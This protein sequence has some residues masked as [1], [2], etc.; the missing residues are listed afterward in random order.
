MGTL[1]TPADARAY[2][3]GYCTSSALIS[4]A[5]ITDERDGNIVPMVNDFCRT[6]I[7][8]PQTVTEYYSGHGD[9][10]L[11][12]NRRNIT[13]LVKVELIAA[14]NI[15]GPFSM[16][17]LILEPNEGLL[18][19]RGNVM[20]GIYLSYFPRGERNIAVTY[21]YGGVLPDDLAMAVK[22]LLCA[23]ILKQLSSR[24]G[25]GDLTVQGFGRRYSNQGKYGI[26]IKQL[27]SDGMM[28]MRRYYSGVV[29]D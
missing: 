6:N 25:G 16:N 11:V 24:T 20:E 28:I 2:L 5:W 13:S 29:G 8:T 14:Y 22:K 9:K 21:T 7:G 26:Y 10:I 3:E 17:S 19:C 23:S 15:I 4:D 27:T 18:I 1:P 12:L